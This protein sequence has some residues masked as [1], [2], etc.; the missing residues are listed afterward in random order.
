MSDLNK[1]AINKSTRYDALLKLIIVGD[2]FVGKS[3]LLLQFVEGYS[4]TE[5]R[6]TIGG[7]FK[8]NTFVCEG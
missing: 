1:M 2:I 8:M 6:S 7:D 3:S 5:H 4:L